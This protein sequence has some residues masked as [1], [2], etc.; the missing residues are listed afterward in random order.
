MRGR[1][2]LRMACRC[3]MDAAVGLRNHTE[4]YTWRCEVSGIRDHLVLTLHPQGQPSRSPCAGPNVS[5]TPA[6]LRGIHTSSLLGSRR[7]LSAE[8]SSVNFQVCCRMYS[9]AHHD[10]RRSH[11]C[12]RGNVYSSSIERRLGLAWSRFKKAING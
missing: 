3:V 6:N 12:N 1:G 8:A 10:N 11:L 4:L 7:P 2:R 5:H 9:N